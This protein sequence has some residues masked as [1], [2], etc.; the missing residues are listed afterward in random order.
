[1]QT[2]YAYATYMQLGAPSQLTV[3]QV[4]TTKSCNAAN[5]DINKIIQINADLL[6][7]KTVN[8][9]E[10]DAVLVELLRILK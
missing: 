8:I 10:N 4:E 9:R 2:I 5:C 3:K 7:A 1:M 6:F